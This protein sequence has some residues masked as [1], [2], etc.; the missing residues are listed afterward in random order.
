MKNLFTALTITLSIMQ[1]YAQQTEIS[2]SDYRI[3]DEDGIFNMLDK[4]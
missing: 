1:L 4:Y 2:R 3:L